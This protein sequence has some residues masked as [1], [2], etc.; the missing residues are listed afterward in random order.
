MATFFG[1]IGLPH[2]LVRFYTNRDGSAARRTTLIVL[3]LLS[4]FYVFP[5]IFA[6]LSR[7]RAPQL[8]LTGDTD[9]IVLALPTLLL[10]GRPGEFWRRLW[11]RERSRL[12]S[13]PPQVCLSAS[14]ARFLTMC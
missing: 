10:H 11:P 14:Q 2:I 4:A 8:Y 7:L 12:S 5:A 9:S 6:V 3:V 13:P 1:A